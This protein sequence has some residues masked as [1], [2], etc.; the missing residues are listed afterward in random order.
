MTVQGLSE[1][2][3]PFLPIVT[4]L[5]A[6]R[7][8]SLGL[9]AEPF[10]EV[11]SLRSIHGPYSDVLEIELRTQQ[12]VWR[13]FVKS[14][15]PAAQ[16]SD[17]TSSPLGPT[18]AE[19]DLLVML[20]DAFQDSPQ[21]GTPRPIAFFPEY[22]ALVTEDV[23]GRN[24]SS[25]LRTQANLFVHRKALDRLA[26]AC[27]RFGHWLLK[28]QSVTAAP[29]HSLLS[30][31]GMREY[32]DQRLGQLVEMRSH[33]V[34]LEWRAGVLGFFDRLAPTV[35]DGARVTVGIHG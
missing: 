22:S 23:G 19:F 31:D 28:F 10:C 4:R 3:E 34:D 30:L 7:P 2:S 15:K 24:F 11:R 26:D 27:R 32:L 17:A 25:E 6:E 33:G 16:W 29:E 12:S 21:F 14:G 1:L 20:W 35:P 13:G 9:G 18:Q 5:V 8:E